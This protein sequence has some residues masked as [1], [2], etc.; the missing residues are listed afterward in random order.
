[1]IGNFLIK[2]YINNIKFLKEKKILYNNCNIMSKTLT[3]KK[4]ICAQ[5]ENILN[6][7]NT[8]LLL[9][10]ST[11]TGD[12]FSLV[13]KT[14]QKNGSHIVCVKKNLLSRVL[15]D[16]FKSLSQQNGSLMMVY[17]NDPLVSISN[18]NKTIRRIKGFNMHNSIVENK[19]LD[20]KSIQSLSKYPDKN[21]ILGVTLSH[22]KIV[23]FQLI[24]VL[25]KIQEK[26]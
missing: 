6:S 19:I 22:I 26:K 2:N 13:R 18:L 17:S 21:S 20:I 12:E 16:E 15:K 14:M 1:M 25:E 7:Y 8:C 4:D 3:Q 10:H 9:E 24:D 11:I 5:I 23:T